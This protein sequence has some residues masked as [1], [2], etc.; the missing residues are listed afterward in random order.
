MAVNSSEVKVSAE[1]NLSNN[2]LSIED[3]DLHFSEL[4]GLLNFNNE[5]GFY[6]ENLRAKLFDRSITAS[7]RT[8][9]LG[10]SKVVLLS[11]EGIR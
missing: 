8:D 11:A 6:A 9:I 2:F 1:I 4:S 10:G 5:S 3:L 7:A